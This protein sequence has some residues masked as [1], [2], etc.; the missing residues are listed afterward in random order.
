MVRHEAT[1]NIFKVLV[2]EATNEIA[3]AIRDVAT[4]SIRSGGYGS[5]GMHAATA[6]RIAKIFRL[7]VNLKATEAKR[8]DSP[9]M[10]RELIDD[11]LSSLVAYTIAERNEHLRATNVTRESA[12]YCVIACGRI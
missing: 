10:G 3:I 5:F 8:C 4:D 1:N 6:D 12:R 2:Q 9:A 11:H 7:A